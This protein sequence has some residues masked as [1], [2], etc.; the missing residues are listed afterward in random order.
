M[1]TAAVPGDEWD[2]WVSLL[3]E[4]WEKFLIVLGRQVIIENV[5]Y[6]PH[7][8]DRALAGAVARA[9]TDTK[10][11]DPN[12]NRR[13]KEFVVKWP[14][15]FT[16]LAYPKQGY[17]QWIPKG[18][19]ADAALAFLT[20]LCGGEKVPARFEREFGLITPP[21][22]R[23]GYSRKDGLRVLASMKLV[24]VGIERFVQADPLEQLPVGAKVKQ[25]HPALKHLPEG[26][27][28]IRVNGSHTNKD[29]E[30]SG[31]ALE[32]EVLHAANH[33]GGEFVDFVRQYIDHVMGVEDQVCAL[34]TEARNSSAQVQLAV[35][36]T[37]ARVEQLQQ[38]ER[39]F[40]ADLSQIIE[41]QFPA[42]GAKLDELLKDR[43]K[44]LQVDF[45]PIAPLLEAIRDTLALN[46]ADARE[47]ATFLA[48]EVDEQLRGISADLAQHDR[49]ES[50]RF[51]LEV[52]EARA[53]RKGV[54]DLQAALAQHE[55]AEQIR[56]AGVA[57]LLRTYHKGAVAQ[58]DFLARRIKAFEEQLA[59]IHAEVAGVKKIQE[60]VLATYA[61]IMTILEQLPAATA[62]QV[63]DALQVRPNKVHYYLKRLCALGLLGREKR[64]P[65][66]AVHA[67]AGSAPPSPEPERVKPKSILRRAWHYF[68]QKR[69]PGTKSQQQ[70]GKTN[71]E[72]T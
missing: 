24:W 12:P 54:A 49:Q 4:Q 57:D 16:I 36:D 7:V 33:Q 1:T 22:T 15:R 43:G 23:L 71:G 66:A 70:P 39:Q 26:R 56:L 2:Y 10:A 62:R 61:A 35:D 53:A 69:Q 40:N 32:T 37:A 58:T 68:A 28:A 59:G 25:K 14:R 30:Y 42:L 29:I 64:D 60:R 11:G 41:K 47:Q 34:Q 45:T 27:A 72:Q 8:E 5:R 31:N 67:P 63:A 51:E 13:G 65:S 50:L 48:Q 46:G 9:G 44:A 20:F 21:I 6:M 3:A 52:T 38:A 17:V 18:T 55:L 19:P